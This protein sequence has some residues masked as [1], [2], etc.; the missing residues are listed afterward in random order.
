MIRKEA[1][2]RGERRIG[3]EGEE[4]GRKEVKET[5]GTTEPSPEGEGKRDLSILFST[6]CQAKT[7]GQSYSIRTSFDNWIFPFILFL[8][9][10][11]C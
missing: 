7:I 1:K 2:R 9:I 10:I 4:G 8:I 3:D 6:S 11:N 5:R